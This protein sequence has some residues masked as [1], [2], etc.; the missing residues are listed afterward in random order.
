[1]TILV[2]QDGNTILVCGDIVISARTREEA[3]AELA[4]RQAGQKTRAA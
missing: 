2:T 3:L 4:R 1:M